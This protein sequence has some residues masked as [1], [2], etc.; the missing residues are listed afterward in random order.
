MLMTLHITTEA[1]R[2]GFTLIE[3]LVVIAIIAILA[4][5][6]L[7]AL[8][9]AKEKALRANCASNLRQIGTGIKM[10]ADENGVMI[11]CH[12]PASANPWRTYE[13]YRVNTGTGNIQPGQGPWNLALLHT[14]KM[15]P[16]PKVFYCPSVRAGAT[17]SHTFDYYNTSAPWPSTPAG[18]GDDNVRTGY[19][20]FPQSKVMVPLGNGQAAKITYDSAQEYIPF[21]ESDVDQ[22]KS[23][24]TDLVQNVDASPHRSSRSV[25][26]LNAMFPDAH[27]AFQN[28]RGNPAAWDT[29]LWGDSSTPI[30]NNP[31]GFRQVMYQWRP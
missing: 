10:Y 14:N 26:G 12:W 29:K 28:A 2:R 25:A 21:K 9:A 23:I 4:A 11:P 7:P 16:N 3:L 24:S 13:V 15:V 22:S 1:R 6:L 31:Q 5:M 27:V 8:A 19:N 20:Y 30:G 18:S 17:D